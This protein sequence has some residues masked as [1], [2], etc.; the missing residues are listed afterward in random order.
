V[1]QKETNTQLDQRH[2]GDWK[3]KRRAARDEGQGQD[4]DEMTQGDRTR[5]AQPSGTTPLERDQAPINQ[6]R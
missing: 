4:V 2:E 5:P 3:D 6:K 1:D